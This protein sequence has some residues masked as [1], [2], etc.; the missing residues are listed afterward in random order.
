M[1]LSIDIA[2]NEGE[3][4][5]KIVQTIILSTCMFL[6]NDLSA[7]SPNSPTLA[8]DS[9]DSVTITN[10]SETSEKVVDPVINANLAMNFENDVKAKLSV[11]PNAITNAMLDYFDK[12]VK[13]YTLSSNARSQIGSILNSYFSSHW[14]FYIDSDWSLKFV[15][16]DKREFEIMVKDV[17]NIVIADMPFWLRKIV[18]PLFLWRNDNIQG[19][20]S[21]LTATMNNMNEKQY[22]SIV[23]DYIPWIIKRV[24]KFVDRKYEFNVWEYYKDISSYYPNENC[25]AILNELRKSGK[26]YTD[27]R[28]YEYKK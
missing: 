18:L 27:I 4:L 22:K 3:T 7:S 24:I 12:E 23:L 13:M 9:S 15:I 20:L 1:R 5:R 14:V 28:D 6:S 8:S 10:N 2:N 21:N 25:N 26:E 19:K 16:D 17:V 11:S